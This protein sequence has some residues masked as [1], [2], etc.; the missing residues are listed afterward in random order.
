MTSPAG[1][2]T[3]FTTVLLASHVPAVYGVT[4]RDTDVHAI[5]HGLFLFTSLLV[6]APLLGVDPLPHRPGRQGRLMCVAACMAPMILIGL[7]L[8][9][10]THPIY[11]QPIAVAAVD[12]QRAAVAIMVV[13]C[14]PALG[15]PLLRR[16]RLPQRL[17]PLALPS[18][19]S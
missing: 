8:A 4:L 12:D 9:T 13:V 17:A 16:A 10:A 11:G 3:L 19:G 1:A 2:V 14:L 15:A 6:W 18:S 7:W 5:E